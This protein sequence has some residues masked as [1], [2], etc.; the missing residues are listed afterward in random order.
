MLELK[1]QNKPFFQIAY[2]FSFAVVHEYAYF[3]I[4][5]C[6]A[7]D[8]EIHLKNRVVNMDFEAAIASA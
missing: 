1:S 2:T 3:A 7:A 8:Y 6:V 5:M 4:K